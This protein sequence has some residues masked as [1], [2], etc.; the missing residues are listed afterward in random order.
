MKL[1]DQTGTKPW[2][3]RISK[4]G[5]MLTD[6]GTSRN[7]L[8]K[9]YP[10]PMARHWNIVSIS[11]P[12]NRESVADWVLRF[13][14]PK[15]TYSHQISNVFNVPSKF[16]LHFPTKIMYCGIIQICTLHF[17]WLILS[18]SRA[19]LIFMV[20]VCWFAF[21]GLVSGSVRAFLNFFFL[22]TSVGSQV[23]LA[24][25][26]AKPLSGFRPQN[27][28]CRA[29]PDTEPST[30]TLPVLRYIR[31]G[32]GDNF[33]GHVRHTGDAY[34]LL[35]LWAMAEDEFVVSP[36]LKEEQSLDKIINYEG[37]LLALDGDTELHKQTTSPPLDDICFLLA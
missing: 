6:C 5:N 18:W 23:P 1:V 25:R 3:I 28:I 10:N 2:H 17:L 37:L 22:T 29:K 30:N 27:Y 7:Q 16:G 14:S 9:Q 19:L 26:S 20:P 21:L 13:P 24:I 35:I 11:C 12:W 8:L 33:A 31:E 34:L 4:M 36:N 15:D 32:K